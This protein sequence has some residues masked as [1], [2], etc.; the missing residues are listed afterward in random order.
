MKKLTN[1]R[2]DKP[3]NKAATNNKK[4]VG[5]EKLKLMLNTMIVTIVPFS[6][7]L[8]KVKNT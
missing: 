3:Q 5:K 1:G 6:L 4:E 8:L 2:I 7:A